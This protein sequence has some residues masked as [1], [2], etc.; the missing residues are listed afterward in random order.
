M[1]IAE[2]PIDRGRAFIKYIPEAHRADLTE[3]KVWYTTSIPGDQVVAGETY[4]D[5]L[6]ET[7]TR[8]RAPNARREAPVE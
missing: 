1:L 8:A 4:G 7:Y 2:P 6:L 3:A 5:V